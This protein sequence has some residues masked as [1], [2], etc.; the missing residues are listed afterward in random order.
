MLGTF[1]LSL[2]VR[3]PAP[4]LAVSVSAS[5]IFFLNPRHPIFS[6]FGHCRALPPTH[7][8]QLLMHSAFNTMQSTST[9]SLFGRKFRSAAA[10][11]SRRVTVRMAQ[12]LKR[13]SCSLMTHV[14]PVC[15][16]LPLLYCSHVAMRCIMTDTFDRGRRKRRFPKFSAAP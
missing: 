8:S 5:F 7:P 6:S 15:P 4:L 1:E 10:S 14:R 11:S 16:T 12:C 2:R 9:L 13:R 3:S